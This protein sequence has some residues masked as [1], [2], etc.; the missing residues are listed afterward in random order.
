MQR[1]RG[2]TLGVIR[3]ESLSTLA[4]GL[5]PA[6]QEILTDDLR[7]LAPDLLLGHFPRETDGRLLVGTTVLLAS[8]ASSLPQIRDRQMWLSVSAPKRRRDPQVVTLT[9]A[10]LIGVNH[11]Q[12][13][14]Q[15]R[16]FWDSRWE[17]ASQEERWGVVDLDLARLGL[18]KHTENLAFFTERC[19]QPAS[20]LADRV[21]LCLLLPTGCATRFTSSVKQ[22]ERALQNFSLSRKQRDVRSLASE[23]IEHCTRLQSY[24]S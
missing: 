10:S 14:D 15:A 6:S 18:E 5:T 16:W 13:W 2:K 11:A 7:Y 17:A 8:Y 21:S 19:A 1:N 22:L 24:F 9:L 20:S 12:R 23:K 3:E 4:Q